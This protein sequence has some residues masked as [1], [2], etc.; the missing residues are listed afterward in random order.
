MGFYLDETKLIPLDIVFSA[1]ILVAWW[2]N[3]H[4]YCAH[5]WFN[6]NINMMINIERMFLDESDL[7]N[8][9]Y[10]FGKHR[11][12]GMLPQ[13]H[14]QLWLG[15]IIGAGALVYIVLKNLFAFIKEAYKTPANCWIDF[16]KTIMHRPDV[17][18]IFLPITFFVMAVIALILLKKKLTLHLGEFEYNS[19][20]KET[21]TEVLQK[22]RYGSA[23]GHKDTFPEARDSQV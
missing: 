12:P 1:I 21:N 2:Q 22:I 23:H 6:R 5:F 9:H 8:I 3:A 7:K 11:G 17:L 18:F 14:V 10:Y 4:V 15:R 13:L 20:G 16:C 19:P